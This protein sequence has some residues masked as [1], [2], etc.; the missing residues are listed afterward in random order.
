MLKIDETIQGLHAKIEEL[1][2][3]KSLGNPPEVEAELENRKRM[4]IEIG[5][6]RTLDLKCENLHE[7][8]VRL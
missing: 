7:E 2:V 6:I 1:A 4:N 5:N 8:S 3:K